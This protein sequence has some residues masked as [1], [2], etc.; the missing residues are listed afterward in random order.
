MARKR[1]T[2]FKLNPEWMFQEPIDFEFNKY[3]LLDYIQKCEQSFDS[4]KIYPDFVEISLHLANVQSINKENTLLLTNKKFDSCDDEILLKEL[5]PKKLPSL[6]DSQENELKRTLL[7]SSSKLMDV[8]NVGKSIWSIVFE[9]TH[10]NHKKNKN[11]LHKG[12]GYLVYNLKSEKELYVWEYSIRKIKKSSDSK[13]HLDS[14]WSGKTDGLTVNQVINEH[15][16][17][18]GDPYQPKLPVFELQSVNHFP[19]EE[20]L[21]PMAKRKLLAYILQSV[22]KENLENFDKFKMIS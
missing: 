22:P 1:K 8:F 2:Q 14:I 15:T 9:S 21:I 16:N 5:Y 6:D 19:F 10:I 7:Y 3:T 18:K 4:F 13:L 11:F 17:W 20:T 12:Y